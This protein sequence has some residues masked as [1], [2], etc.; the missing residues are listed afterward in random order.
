[1]RYKIFRNTLLFIFILSIFSS[2]NLF[3]D[4][5]EN[6]PTEQYL[7]SS[8]KVATYLPALIT[9]ILE[10]FGANYPEIEPIIDEI[11]H[12]VTVYKISYITTFNG[13]D[14]IAS[15]LVSIPTSMGVYPVLS[16][17][18]GTNTEHSKA[19]SVNPDNE[20][21]LLLEFMAS[22]GFVVTIPDYLGFGTSD[23]MFHPYLDKVSTVQSVLDMQ[24]AVKE[25]IANY[26]KDEIGVELNNDYYITGYSQGG[27]TTMQLQKTIEEKYSDVFNLKASV[28]AAGPYDL[29]YVNEYVLDLEDYPMPYFLGYIFNSYYNLDGITTPVD[30]IFKE[31]FDTK[32][33]TLYDGTKSGAEINDELDTKIS[34]LFTADYISGYSSE[35]KY[36][37][38]KDMLTQNSVTAWKTTTPTMLI[39]GSSD[40]FVPPLVTSRIFQNFQN[41]GVG[42]D[43]IT[44]VSVP[45]GTHQ[46]TI[47]PAGIAAISW[48]LEI[49][50]EE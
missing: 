36:A 23:D 13:D 14:V 50:N 12:G 42:P 27:W 39:H 45:G 40:M 17:Q 3:N 18:N 21:F 9:S 32:V 8:E 48:F 16:Y 37:S 31:P 33:L 24:R 25:F 34:R 1:M 11:E 6:L 7:V 28:C 35:A 15:G 38:V 19:P 2:C 30:E 10:Q 26:L 41:E 22:T 47:I 29:N 46:S 4:D 49:K 20:L 43:R 44:M 5:T